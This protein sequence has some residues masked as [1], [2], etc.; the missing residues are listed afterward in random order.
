[1]LSKES[2]VYIL[3]TI[4][5]TPLCNDNYLPAV[6]NWKDHKSNGSTNGQ[7]KKEYK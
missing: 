2:L 6:S 3:F 1:M 7:G 5:T 4:D